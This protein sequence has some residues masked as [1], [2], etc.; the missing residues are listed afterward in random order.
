MVGVGASAGGLEALQDFFGAMPLD[1]GASFVVIQH[2]SPDYRSLMDELLAR[3][4][5]IPIVVA[6]DGMA[7]QKNHIYLLPPRKNIK[8]FRNQFFLEDQNLKK[9]LNLPVDI[10][11][12]SLA[13]ER[14]K[15]A[16][17][18]ILSGT[19]SDGTLGTRALKEAGGMVMVQSELTAKFDGM[20]RSSISTG[21]VDFIL[22]PDKMPDALVNYIKHPLNLQKRES[23]D[24]SGV[25]GDTLSKIVMIMRNH[26]GI[27][28]SY[29]KE[30][31][32]LR[33]LE[34]RISINRFSSL[35]EYLPLLIE[36]DKEK[37]VLNKELLIGVTRFF[38]D[39][40][41][42]DSLKSKVLPQWTGKKN[43]RIWST[44]C[45]TGEEV[46]SLA[47]TLWE[48]LENQKEVAEVKIFATDVDQSALDYASKGFYPD[49]VMADVDPVYLLKYFQ[50]TEAGYQV[51]DFIRKMV[52]FAAHNLLKDSPFSKLDLL[53]CR[54]LFIYLRPEVQSR[55][56]A[57]FYSS[58][59]PGGFLFLGSS[60]SIGDMTEAFQC[61]DTRWKI[62]A[63]R[64]EFKPEIL[65]LPP[66][67]RPPA[68]MMEQNR[69]DRPRG[70]PGLRFD[71]LL[72]GV[73]NAFLPP[74]V[75]LDSGENILHV[76]GDVS[77][78]VRLSPGKFSQNIYS[79]LSHDMGLFVSTLLRRIRTKESSENETVEVALEDPHPRKI[80]ITGRMLEVDRRE[81]LLLSF[82]QAESAPR[83]GTWETLALEG[84]V[85]DR[86]NELE[87][88]LQFTRESLQATVEELETSNEELQSSNEELIASNE[89]LQST[90]EELQSVNE[91][92]FTVNSEY[93]QKIEELTRLNNDEANL[94]RNTEVGALYLD[95]NLCIRKV[96]PLVSKIT[97]ILQSDLGR[98]VSHLSLKTL[99]DQFLPAL[100]QV[101]E[102]LQPRDLEIVTDQKVTYLTRIRP[103]RTEYNAVEGVLVIFVDISGLKK[104]YDR[105]NLATGRLSEALKAGDMA[106][107]ELH[108]VRRQFLQDDR[109]AT[110]LGYEPESF[111][112]TLEEYEA[113]IH[114]DDLGAY[115]Q[116]FREFQ[117]SHQELWQL[118]YRIRRKDG[119]WAVYLDLIRVLARDQ[120]GKHLKLA[121]TVIDVSRLRA[122]ESGARTSRAAL[123]QVM[124]YTPVAS[125]VVDG[126]GRIVFANSAAQSLLG[127]S[128]EEIRLRTF[129]ASEWVITDREGLPIPSEDLPYARIRRTG[130]PLGDVF[131]RIVIP[132]RDSLS[133]LVSGA[134][135]WG[136]GGEFQG[137][138]FTLKEA[139]SEGQ[140]K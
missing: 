113:L 16:I 122:V 59:S 125:T 108:M 9:G 36:S 112:K 26:S 45:S 126:G 90:N 92:L 21:L 85:L 109:R 23:Q 75:V 50:K 83:P 27:D 93:Q 31:T 74:S 117:T 25:A 131:Q 127:I 4:T 138:L 55:I 100:D 102:T 137:V 43:L 99:G 73:A 98:P 44:G 129:D 110:M 40:E 116:G 87:R 140:C 39:Q 120:F 107:W 128:R 78:Y 70:V 134:P 97:Q 19:G 63:C 103:Y 95:R 37:S 133:L 89:E 33:R 11:F 29:Y 132:D 111:P 124:E 104:E 106:W 67:N 2:L 17:G 84:Q 34:R 48:F 57:M 88:E 71:R 96:T 38:R 46:Y 115:L 10:F 51:R 14:G 28:F 13:Q 47:I 5:S 60:E 49:S 123:E 18:V 61:L 12:Q 35:E 8:I 42:F 22:P 82:E 53:V 3:H 32:L 30:A 139:E 58:L 121:G 119:T 69:V 1:T 66:P 52:V 24:P 62:Y 136:E 118:E 130:V 81:F 68:E 72:E 114:P 20:P 7:L 91:E 41:A 6:Q 80:R 94:L 101:V 86:V 54:N 105:A 76:I 135:I 56:L 79:N 77:P 64:Q 15:Y 65:H